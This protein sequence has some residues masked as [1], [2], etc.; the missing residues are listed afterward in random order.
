MPETTEIVLWMKKLK[1]DALEQ[2]LKADRAADLLTEAA[3]RAGTVDG[4]AAGR[5]SAAL[6]GRVPGSLRPG[7]PNRR[8]GASAVFDGA[9]LGAY[10]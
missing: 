3:G 6:S 7:S 4:S 1:Y 2:V 5:L 8:S 9:G 10:P